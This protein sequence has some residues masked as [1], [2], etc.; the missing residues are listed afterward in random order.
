MQVLIAQESMSRNQVYVFAKKQPSKY[1]YTAEIRS[2]LESGSLR[3]I[4]QGYCAGYGLVVD[5]MIL[6]GW[7]AKATAWLRRFM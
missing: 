5:G 3:H 1:A 4:R 2:C 7:N 6:I